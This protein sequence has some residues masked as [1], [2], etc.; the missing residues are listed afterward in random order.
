MAGI[1]GALMFLK[2]LLVPNIINVKTSVFR[3]VALCR[4]VY[5]T[6]VT[7]EFAATLEM[8]DFLCIHHP[9][10]FNSHLLLSCIKNKLLIFEK[11]LNN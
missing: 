2:K 5:T 6:N 10:N 7:E 9:K 8:T 4:L 1:K 3:D 11:I